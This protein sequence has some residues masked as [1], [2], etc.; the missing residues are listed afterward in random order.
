MRSKTAVTVFAIDVSASMDEEEAFSF[1]EEALDSRP[2]DEYVKVILF[3]E[4]AV[5]V[6]APFHQN[7]AVKKGF[8]SIDEAL[9]LANA[10]MPDSVKKRVVLIS[11]GAENMGDARSRVRVLDQRGVTVSAAYVKKETNENEVQ[12]TS[13]K[14]PE[15]LRKDSEYAV[16]ATVHALSDGDARIVV[17]KNNELIIND[18]IS[19]RKGENKYIFSDK[20]GEGGALAYRAEILPENDLFS[21]NNAAYAYGAAEGGVRALLIENGGGEH[22]AQILRRAGVEVIAAKPWFAPSSFENLNIYDAVILADVSMGDFPAGFDET[23]ESYVKNA[24]GG[25]MMTGGENSYALG[26]WTDTPVEA[27]L[28]VNMRLEDKENSPNLG[29]IIVIDRSGSMTSGRYGVSKLE[30]AKEAVIRSFE[31]LEEKDS[32]GVVAFDDQFHWASPF[33]PVKG[34]S[35][36]E[37]VANISPG[38]GT[39]I[40]PGLTEAYETLADADVKQKHIVLLTDGQAEQSG[41][42]GLAASMRASGITL[43]TVAVGSD[44]DTKLL[45]ALASMG[46]GRYYYS[47]EF[48]DLPKIFAKETN[49]AGRRFLNNDVFYPSVT[50]KGQIADI[51]LDGADAAPPLGG[52][53]AT[54][55]KDRADIVLAAPNGEPALAAWQYGLGKSVAWTS[56][57]SGVWSAEWINSAAGECIFLNA[58]S[59][60]ARNRKNVRLTSRLDGDEI[61]L[62]MITAYSDGVSGADGVIVAPD[63][64]TFKA[65]FKQTAPGEFKATIPSGGEGVYMAGMDIETPNGVESVFSGVSAPYSKEY[66][67]RAD[68]DGENL[69]KRLVV[70][71]GAI[72]SSPAEAFAQDT[73]DVGERRDISAYALTAAL[74]LFLF[75]IALRRFPFILR[76][77]LSAVAGVRDFALRISGAPFAQSKKTG[78]KKRTAKPGGQREEPAKGL[79]ESVKETTRGDTSGELLAKKKRR[80]GM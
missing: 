78:L 56:D 7:A 20:T 66:D 79:E 46:G 45:T 18:N 5:S 31:T 74:L 51:I 55:R 75:D 32:F 27:A 37:D 34:S 10:L 11:D 48:T 44:S 30:L 24:G 1:L 22:V 8:T 28:P 2:A 3:G 21:E 19:Y 67:I 6:D 14:V 71:G 36:T 61:E 26:D 43:S 68:Y 4:N 42:A 40:L 58:F 63:G 25:L 73:T 13:I 17:Y 62:T 49:L 16:E 39:S 77:A 50:D 47:D 65:A 54:T 15:F 76:F 60:T 35:A 72:I 9:K 23:L 64:Q 80:S 41:Y 38:G 52:Y 29:M 53:V 59:W 33:Q 57:M 12:L 70:G 69:L